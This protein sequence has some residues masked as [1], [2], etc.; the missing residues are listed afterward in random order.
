MSFSAQVINKAW[1]RSKG[2]CENCGKKLSSGSRGKETPMG[3]E[4]HHITPV[5]KGGE[6]TLSNCKILC[7][8]CHKNTHSFGKH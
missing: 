7:Q 8:E 5:L 4:A 1:K 3:W 2:K 6:D